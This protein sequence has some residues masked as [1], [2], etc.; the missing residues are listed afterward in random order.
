MAPATVATHGAADPVNHAPMQILRTL[1]NVR[2]WKGWNMAQEA[3]RESN[4]GINFEGALAAVVTVGGGRGF[5]VEM[6]RQRVIITAAH[7]LPEM[8]PPCSNAKLQEVTYEPLL[9]RLNSP[10]SILA[11]CLFVDPV[12]DI[13]VLGGPDSQ[14]F[15]DEA[16]AFDELV[17]DV[18]ALTIAAAND[19]QAWMLSLK[20]VWS[21]CALHVPGAK[22]WAAGID[23]KG[24]MPGI[25]AGMS[26]S[27]ILS[28]TGEAVGVICNGSPKGLPDLDAPPPPDG[29]NNPCL[30]MTLPARLLNRMYCAAT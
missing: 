21:P 26:G 30:I 18:P 10:P 16:C 17:D 29:Y 14:A 6:G 5:I 25:A 15:Y 28:P 8:P 4:T 12:A 1:V 2:A 23:V 24:Y 13:A 19:G 9:A 27:P 3:E 20:G 22:H 11:E 7:C